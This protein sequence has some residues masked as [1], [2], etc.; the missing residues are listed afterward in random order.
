MRAG[1]VDIVDD[2][3]VRATP[4]AVRA[5]LDAAGVPSSAPGRWPLEVRVAASEDRGA[6]GVRWAAAGRITGRMEVWLEEVPAGTV[7]HHYVRG[8]AT[9]RWRSPAWVARDHT[10]T[11]K[12]VV[13]EVKDTLEG[14]RAAPDGR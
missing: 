2:T 9:H 1:L 7:V 8:E 4:P 5:A 6:K 12:Q 3:F 11:W 13:H 10:L 14:R